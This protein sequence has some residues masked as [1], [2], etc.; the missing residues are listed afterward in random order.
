MLIQNYQEMPYFLWYHKN[1]NFLFFISEISLFRN[2]RLIFIHLLKK[3]MLK[4]C[5]ISGDTWRVILIVSFGLTKFNVIFKILNNY[6]FI[7]F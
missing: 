7:N 4:N 6:L 5:I 2:N 3:F 1:M